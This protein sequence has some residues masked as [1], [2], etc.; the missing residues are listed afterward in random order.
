MLALLLF[1]QSVVTGVAYMQ[2]AH[3]KNFFHLFLLAVS[4]KRLVAAC[5]TRSSAI[6]E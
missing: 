3:F 1:L 2:L 4:G 6:A 5:K